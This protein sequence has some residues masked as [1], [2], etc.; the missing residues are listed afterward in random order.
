MKKIIRKILQQFNYD[1]IKLN[2]TNSTIPSDFEDLHKRILEKVKN[3]TMTSAE[4]IYSLIEAVKY[5]E[6]N[7]IPG[8]IVECGVWKGGSM[9]AVAETLKYLNNTKRHLYLYDTY[10]GMS[11]PTEHDRTWYGE[12]ASALLD[13]ETNKEKN[14]VWA[15]SALDTVKQGMESTGYPSDKIKY[16]KG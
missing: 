3:N 7:N 10:E 15:Y 11:E 2:R 14:I 8:D 4:R 6:R 13:L 16:V 12:S 9:M 1:I 5:I